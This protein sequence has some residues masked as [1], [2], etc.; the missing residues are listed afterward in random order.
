[1]RT[2]LS[3][4]GR[5]NNP[6]SVL[7]TF[8]LLFFFAGCSGYDAPVSQLRDKSIESFNSG[9]E[10]EAVAWA[11]KLAVTDSSES[12]FIL[13][14]YII[15]D[16]VNDNYDFHRINKKWYK[17][18]VNVD[19][20][21]VDHGLREKY[22]TAQVFSD[23]YLNSADNA[24]TL[25]SERCKAWITAD[26]QVCMDKIIIS[27]RTS[28]ISM[29]NRIGALYLTEAA[30]VGH[31]LKLIDQRSYEYNSGIAFAAIDKRRSLVTL[32]NLLDKGPLSGDMKKTY[33]SILNMDFYDSTGR[34]LLGQVADLKEYQIST[35]C[36]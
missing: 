7:F 26:A 27:V 15:Y 10:V 30:E 5:M 18:V 20:S 13:A 11:K 2:K 9:R 6:R 23:I 19:L 34:S 8:S 24:M 1:M 32:R 25:L 33:C 21:R 3:L 36:Q 14:Q 22:I 17:S 29:P 16:T 35:T 4:A 28:Y 12:D 31:R